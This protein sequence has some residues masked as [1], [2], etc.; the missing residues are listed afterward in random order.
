MTIIV[1]LLPPFVHDCQAIISITVF[2]PLFKMKAFLYH[3]DV[4]K[5]FFYKKT[6]LANFSLER[7]TNM[8]R[9]T[10]SYSQSLNSGIIV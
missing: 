1:L 8:L 9:Y 2:A 10:R 6:I 5:T 4:W 7:T 3:F